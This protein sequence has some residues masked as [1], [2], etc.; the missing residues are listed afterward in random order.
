MVMVT[1]MTVAPGISRCIGSQVTIVDQ[2]EETLEQVY[3]LCPLGLG[4][5][6]VNILPEEGRIRNL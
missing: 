4:K 6:H 2:I 3:G 1:V 5:C